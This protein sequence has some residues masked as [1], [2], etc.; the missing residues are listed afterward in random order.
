ML[1]FTDKYSM[2]TVLK[3]WVTSGIWLSKMTEQ[4]AWGLTDHIANL[5][6][7]IKGIEIGVQAGINS[8]MLLD[9][10]PN[11]SKIVGVDPFLAYPDWNRNVSQEE[12]D[13]AYKIFQE[14]L[15]LLGPKFEHVKLKAAE[16]ATQL[17]DESYDFV[18]IDGDHSL[19]A[20]LSD[21]E[22]YVPKIKIGGIIAGHD[23]GLQGVN[24]ALQ[25]WCRRK[26]ISFNDVHLVENQS[27]YWIK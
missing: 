10:C 13:R 22:H 12:Q 19:R 21:L 18:F 27:W 7:N 2:T 26:G 24:M 4:A 17:E 14:N 20:V 8:M 23:V 5:G 9:A 1:C 3:E 25:T 6:P 15:P 16:A 11:I